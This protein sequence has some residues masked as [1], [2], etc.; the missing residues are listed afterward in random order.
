MQTTSTNFTIY[1][2][3]LSGARSKVHGINRQLALTEFS[4]LISVETWFNREV[5]TT[6]LTASTPYVGIRG[7][8]ANYK[9]RCKEGGGILILLRNEYVYRKLP[10][11]SELGFE[12]LSL[13]LDFAGD[14]QI[15]IALYQ[16]SNYMRT[17]VALELC[18]Y[19]KSIRSTRNTLRLPYFHMAQRYLPFQERLTKLG[20]LTFHGRLVLARCLTLFKIQKGLIETNVRAQIMAA[21]TARNAEVRHARHFNVPLDHRTCVTRLMTTY[22]KLSPVINESQAVNTNKHKIRKYLIMNQFNVARNAL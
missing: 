9:I 2:Q 13:E 12:H 7:D 5:L 15:I 16:S 4:M 20:T 8:R 22:N 18:D 17:K 1:L 6:E 19:I 21:R 3:N 14:K 11:N 10:V